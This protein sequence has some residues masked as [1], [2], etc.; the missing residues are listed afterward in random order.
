[1]IPFFEATAVAKL[2][3]FLIADYRHRIGIDEA[4]LEQ[5]HLNRFSLSFS[6]FFHTIIVQPLPISLSS[7]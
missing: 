3:H 1:M 4:L 2:L 7:S 6:A 5:E